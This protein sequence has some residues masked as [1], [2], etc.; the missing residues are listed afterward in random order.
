[1]RQFNE[2]NNNKCPCKG[3]DKR[4]VGC[5]GKCTDFKT[6]QDELQI[7]REKVE[8]DR[9]IKTYYIDRGKRVPKKYARRNRFD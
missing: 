7:I 8:K 6:Y 3:C 9:H 5:H 2:R 4:E 1:M